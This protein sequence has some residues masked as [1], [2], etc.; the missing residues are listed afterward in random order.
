[1]TRFV[2]PTAASRPTHL[3]VGPDRAIWFY[4]S[5]AGKIGRFRM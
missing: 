1:V 3:T 2:V 4:Q 5:A